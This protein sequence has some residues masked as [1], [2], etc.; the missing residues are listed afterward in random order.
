MNSGKGIKSIKRASLTSQAFRLDGNVPLIQDTTEL[1]TPESAKKILANNRKNRPINWRKVEEYKKIMLEGKWKLHAQGIII[2][3]NGNLLTGQKRLHA[4]LLC[5]QPQY[6]RI[7]RGSPPETA[8]L[9]DRGTP[10]SGRDLASRGTDRKHSVLEAGLVRAI[11]ALNKTLRPSA[12]KIADGLIKYNDILK[13][14]ISQ[15]KGYKK[16]K[17]MQMIIAAGCTFS[18]IKA[19]LV[20]SKTAQLS[21][22][23]SNELGEELVEE[24]WGKGSAFTLCMEHAKRICQQEIDKT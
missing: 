22:E 7:S 12:D 3:K 14:A 11:F 20:F 18:R 4:I 16:N 9:I 24:Y 2:D 8:N 5:G 19:E 15:T 13:I 6:M 23:L 17:A 10:Q 21:Q 1:V